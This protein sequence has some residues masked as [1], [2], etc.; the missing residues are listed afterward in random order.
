MANF[1]HFRFNL[2]SVVSIRAAGIFKAL[3]IPFWAIITGEQFQGEWQLHSF[4]PEILRVG[5]FN[6]FGEAVCFRT[7]PAVVWERKMKTAP[8]G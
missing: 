8:V 3:P 5:P 6:H 4:R 1:V 2:F 7:V